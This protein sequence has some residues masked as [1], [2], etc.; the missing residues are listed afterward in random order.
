MSDHALGLQ[1]LDRVIEGSEGQF[2][3][4]VAMRDAGEAAGPHEVDALQ[5]RL[6]DRSV[7]YATIWGPE[8]GADH[9]AAEITRFWQ[10]DRCRVMILSVAG[11]RSLNLQNASILVSIDTDGLDDAAG[12]AAIAG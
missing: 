5:H 3:L 7:G 12:L 9:R 11:E 8:A 1:P 4:P 6:A 10:D 2:D